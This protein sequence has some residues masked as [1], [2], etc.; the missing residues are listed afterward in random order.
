MN[1]DTQERE[2]TLLTDAELDAVAGGAQANHVVMQEIHFA[3]YVDKASP[4]L[5]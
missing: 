5:S 1:R 2:T 3:K 4:K